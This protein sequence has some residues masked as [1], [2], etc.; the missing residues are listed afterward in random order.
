MA[1]CTLV[2]ASKIKF[3]NF[4][5]EL[6]HKKLRCT[7]IFTPK[8]YGS[9][10]LFGLGVT[11]MQHESSLSVG[12]CKLD[13]R[14]ENSLVRCSSNSGNNDSEDI[15]MEAKRSKKDLSNSVGMECLL[16]TICDTTSIAEFK[17]NLAGFQLYVKR[18]LV[19]KNI[20]SLGPSHHSIQTSTANQIPESNGSAAITSIAVSKTKTS[21]SSI[22]RIVD[23]A[24]DEGLM[25]LQSPKVGLFRRSRTIEGKKT[26]PPCKEKEEVKEG[27][28]LCYIEQ[29]G[30]EIPIESDVSGEVIK[31][32]RED[33][34]P[35][36]YG[37]HLIAILPSF[38]GIKKLQ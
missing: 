6:K 15:E 34:E 8:T 21:S 38:P 4:D 27:Q 18:D 25:I 29:L 30:G 3:V 24:S 28:V 17:M 26:P 32:L 31:I 11:R 22:Q 16:T 9:E 23:T 35:V 36:G 37:D 7:R 13:S 33:G 20:P 1:A 2:Y 14:P 12:T 19:E 5:S 10:I